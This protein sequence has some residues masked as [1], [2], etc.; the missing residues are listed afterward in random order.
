MK[1]LVKIA[2]LV[3]RSVAHYSHKPSYHAYIIL[4][5][6]FAVRKLCRNWFADASLGYRLVTSE[7]I[8]NGSIVKLIILAII[9]FIQ[10]IVYQLQYLKH[11]KPL[12]DFP[13]FERFPVLICVTIIWIYSLILT[14][15]GAYRGKPNT[16]QISCRTDRAN[17]ISTAPWWR[18]CYFLK[19]FWPMI[20]CESKIYSMLSRFKFPY[21]L[22]WGAPTFAAGHCF[23]MMSAVLVSMVE[24]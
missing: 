24:V 14:A 8:L 9:T 18:F 2:S 12:R 4:L 15:S 1:F 16:T 13:I 11:I 19:L 22:Q 17:L 21:P 20:L 5:I 6:C 7:F 10:V 3:H 23:A